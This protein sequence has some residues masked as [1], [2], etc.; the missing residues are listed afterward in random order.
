MEHTGCIFI[1]LERAGEGRLQKYLSEH[2]HSYNWILKEDEEN[3]KVRVCVWWRR[4]D[5]KQF[6]TTPLRSFLKRLKNKNGF[7]LVVG[8]SERISTDEG[9]QRVCK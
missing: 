8:I 2:V 9:V 4:E 1:E 6:S 3:W 7:P 5:Y